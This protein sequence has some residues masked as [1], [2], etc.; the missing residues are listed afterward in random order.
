MPRSVPQPDERARTRPAM[1]G[2][3]SAHRHRRIRP[4]SPSSLGVDVA[5]LRQ[6]WAGPLLPR[7]TD[8][9]HA[10]MDRVHSNG[11][12]LP[13]GELTKPLQCS[14]PVPGRGASHDAGRN[15]GVALSL[16]G[17]RS[18]T[19]RPASLACVRRSKRTDSCLAFPAA[20]SPPGEPCRS[21][22][23]RGGTPG[24]FRDV[25]ASGGSVGGKWTRAGERSWST[26]LPTPLTR[27]STRE[28][29]RNPW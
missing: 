27:C 10:S 23:T 2:V 22:S 13:M 3:R 4:R 25:G 28:T 26:A 9:A 14:R 29:M 19:G 12:T 16:L 8:P 17:R 21:R 7:R 18:A 6:P 15:V 24:D 11:V 1:P 5:D 20:S